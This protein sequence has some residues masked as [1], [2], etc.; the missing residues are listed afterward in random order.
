MNGSSLANLQCTSERVE[1]LGLPWLEVL[2]KGR[3]HDGGEPTMACGDLGV[4]EVL[5]CG[6]SQFH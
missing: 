2:I 4:R 1:V 6:G 5:P 3:A